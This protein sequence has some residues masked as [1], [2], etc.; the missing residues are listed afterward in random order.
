MSQALTPEYLDLC[1]AA[2][3]AEG[4]GSDVAEFL[5]EALA[6]G[7]DHDLPRRDVRLA[8]EAWHRKRVY[9]GASDHRP[10]SDHALVGAM[11]AEGLA[12]EGAHLFYARWKGVK[13]K[14]GKRRQ[15]CR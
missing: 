5:A 14:Y 8:Y 11:L 13:F 6:F 12:L 2:W 15:L 3:A 1:R 4:E 9:C 7:S 10:L